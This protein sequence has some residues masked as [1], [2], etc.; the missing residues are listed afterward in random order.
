MRIDADERA[1]VVAAGKR[2]SSRST[3]TAGRQAGSVRFRVTVSGQTRLPRAGARW[4]YAVRAVMYSGKRF[5]GTAIMQV[6]VGGKVVDTIG[7]F[8]FKGLLRKTYRFNPVL[9]GKRAVLRAK[10]IGPGGRRIVGYPV[11]VR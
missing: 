8:G 11:R 6:V 10:V 7:W 5:S 2:A 1:R 3:V 9:R 4:R